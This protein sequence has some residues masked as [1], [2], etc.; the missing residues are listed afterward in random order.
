MSPTIKSLFSVVLFAWATRATNRRFHSLSFV[1]QTTLTL[2]GSLVVVT[3]VYLLMRL[4]DIPG[5][6]IG[7]LDAQ[8]L[9][10]LVFSAVASLALAQFMWIRGAAGLRILLASLH[11]N[12]V[13]FYV[14]VIVALPVLERKLGEIEGQFRLRGGLAIPL[15]ALSISVWL[16]SH[17]SLKSWWVTGAFLLAGSVLYFLT[18]QRQTDGQATS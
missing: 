10:L 7:V 12:A 18:R 17:A 14:M 13:P 3:L 1:G 9:G 16:M 2:S 4:L 6:G 5:T 11:M 15:L 8:H